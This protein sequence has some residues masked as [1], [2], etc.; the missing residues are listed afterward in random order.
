MRTIRALAIGSWSLVVLLLATWVGSAGA[1]AFP[2]RS[3]PRVGAVLRAAPAQVRIWFDGDLE[4]AFSALTVTS[5]AGQRVDRG[6][7]VVDAQDR[8]LL[9]VSLPGLTPGVYRVIWNVLSVDG[10]RTE[11]DFTFTVRAAE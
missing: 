6:D 2:E 9:R 8:R 7:A 4:P 1:H 5:I 11:G 3:E 10:H